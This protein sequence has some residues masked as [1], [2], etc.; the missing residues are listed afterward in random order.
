[1]QWRGVTEANFNLY[2]NSIYGIELE[3]DDSSIRTFFEN[4]S[5]TI[6]NLVA[7][8]IEVLSVEE[9]TSEAKQNKTEYLNSP[10]IIVAE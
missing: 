2:C 4:S 1:M 7:E 3:R 6:W 5:G 10:H 8:D 9:S